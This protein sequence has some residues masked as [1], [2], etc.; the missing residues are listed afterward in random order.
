MSV[1]RS[2]PRVIT[3]ILMA[4]VSLLSLNMFLPSL[5]QMAVDFDT[6]YAIVNISVA[7]YLAV[8]ALL[9]LVMGPLSDRY[10]RRPVLL[11]GLGVFAIASVGC[12]F[13]ENIWIFLLFRMLQAGV[14][15]A[16]VLS[17]AI[18]SDMYDKQQAASLM[19]YV[20]MIMAVAPM[21]G[22]M[23]GGL[24]EQF[25]H[26]RASFALYAVF[27]IGLVVL[28]WLDVGET[29]QHP[30]ATFAAQFKSYPELLQ[31]RRFWGYSL[32]TAF[33][34]GTFF[35][36]LGG[37][38]LA[39]SAAFDLSPAWLGV[40]MGCTTAGFFLG[41]FVS[42]QIAARLQL[43]SL[44]TIGRL[45]TLAGLCVGAAL[46]AGGLFHPVTFFASVV[47]VGIGNGLTLPAGN[48][49]AMSVRPRLAGSA[50]GLSGAMQVGGGAALTVLSGALISEGN[51]IAILMAMLIFCS[52][53]GLVAALYVLRIDR[54]SP[55]PE[56]A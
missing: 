44:M 12:L 28:G 43:S 41:N 21:M 50:S 56:A 13:A 22:P 49:G 32:C 23:V 46:M 33:S 5:A 25:L 26:W 31:S 19:G 27:G 42:G 45:L 36:F 4:A 54:Q 8:S 39:A 17:R 3:L 55:L 38:P 35:I 18:I 34:V 53:L 2:P 37:A 15:S 9:Q 1:R 40:G 7:G 16:S 10:G 24:L 51:G 6:S 20:A 14:V 47:F 30:S 52:L 29:N 48:A 11:V